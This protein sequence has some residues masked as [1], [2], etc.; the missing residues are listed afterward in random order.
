VP[1]GGEQFGIKTPIPAGVGATALGMQES[2]L[3]VQAHDPG[4]GMS[5]VYQFGPQDLARRG[6]GTDITN[7]NKQVTAVIGEFEKIKTRGA[8][9]TKDGRWAG[10]AHFL[11]HFGSPSAFSSNQTALAKG[12]AFPP[13]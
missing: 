9:R 12:T 11:D 1:P 5:G 2:S 13:S 6:L 7:V 10:T 3:R 4:H 8:I